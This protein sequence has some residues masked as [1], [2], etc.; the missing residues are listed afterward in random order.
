MYCQLRQYRLAIWSIPVGDLVNSGW[1]FGQ[2][3]MAIRPIPVGDW[4]NTSWRFGQYRRRYIFQDL[5][6]FEVGDDLFLENDLAPQ[7]RYIYEL[8]LNLPFL[9]VWFVCQYHRV[10]IECKLDSFIRRQIDSSRNIR[11][12]Q[13]GYLSIKHSRQIDSHADASQ[14]VG[15]IFINI[16][17][18]FLPLC[19][20]VLSTRNI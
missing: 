17:C 3:R 6:R 15:D 14:G 8:N 7:R 10:R 9:V 19:I 2:Y 1:K 20:S 5:G 18:S 16:S 13:F 11:Q 12:H 4:A